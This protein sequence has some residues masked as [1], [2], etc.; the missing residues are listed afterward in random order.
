MLN[1]LSVDQ[2][3]GSVPADVR[4]CALDHCAV[5]VFPEAISDVVSALAVEGFTVDRPVPSVV[6]KSRLCQRYRLSPDHIDVRIV[7]GSFV[8]DQFGRREIEVFAA[9][10]AARSALPAGLVECERNAMNESHVA[11][12]VH[13]PE[14]ALAELR[15]HLLGSGV[16]AAD[17]AGYNPFE[18]SH[19]GGRTVL[20]FRSREGLGNCWPLHRLELTCSGEYAD[21]IAEHLRATE[22]A[23][24]LG[25]SEYV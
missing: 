7:R 17:G 25:A 8:T 6:V 24:V 20:Y 15:H 23:P 12:L 13:Q 14:L 16:F 18:K 9:M 11:I 19:E 5:L 3:F 1:R 22:N 10:P 4:Y 2:V 21:V